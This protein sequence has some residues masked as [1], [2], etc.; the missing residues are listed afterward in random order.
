MSLLVGPWVSDKKWY[1]K[2][3]GTS[4]FYSLYLTATEFKGPILCMI[5]C[6]DLFLVC[7]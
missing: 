7:Q 4:K 5:S 1:E 6:M 2:T 3:A